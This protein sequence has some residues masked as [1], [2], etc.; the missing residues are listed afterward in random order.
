MYQL[1]KQKKMQSKKSI[2]TCKFYS[3]LLKIHY[4]FKTKTTWKCL[5]SQWCPINV[6]Y[7]M[8]ISY[9]ICYQ[10]IMI[11]LKRKGFFFFF[12]KTILLISQ[13]TLYSA[14]TNIKHWSWPEILHMLQNVIIF[15]SQTRTFPLSLFPLNS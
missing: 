2:D 5:C 11:Y 8:S 13:F 15:I 12:E 3:E 14:T 1:L 7:Q 4:I 10:I 9:R 6:Y